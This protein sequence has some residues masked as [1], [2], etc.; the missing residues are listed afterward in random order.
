MGRRYIAAYL[1]RLFRWRKSTAVNGYGR[2][3]SSRTD[4][5]RP[6]RI[7]LMTR[8]TLRLGQ[9]PSID[10]SYADAVF[11][12]HLPDHIAVEAANVMPCFRFH[13]E[14]TKLAV[15]LG[16]ACMSKNRNSG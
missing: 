4:G 1:P 9:I 12:S 5:A 16:R 2:L 13:L 8:M 11:P 14:M 3:V 6:Y 15:L 10:L 7:E